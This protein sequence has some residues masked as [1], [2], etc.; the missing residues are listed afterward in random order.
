MDLGI[1]NG[2][3]GRREG[4]E[5][6]EGRERWKEGKGEGGKGIERERKRE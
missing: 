6:R 5:K 1:V 3:E 4:E 2:R